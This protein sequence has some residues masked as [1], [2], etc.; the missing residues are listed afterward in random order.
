M[1]SDK[2]TSTDLIDYN[3]LVGAVNRI[4]ENDDLIPST[5][6]IF[7]DW[8]SG[9]SSLMRMV[10][11][12]YEG[13][14]EILT[15]K[16]N[17][18]LFEGYE[19]AKSVL[20][21]TILEEIATNRTLSAEAKEIA[22]RLFKKIDWLKLAKN[23][24]KYGVSLATLGPV[25]LGISALSDLPKMLSEV[26]Y[27][28]FI[29]SPDAKDKEESLRMSIREFHSDFKRLLSETKISKLIV[30]IDDLDRCMPDT[31]IDTLEAIKLFLYTD[32]TA[33]VISADEQL[34]E[35]AVSKR[36]PK[37]EGIRDSVSRDYLEKLIQYPIRIPQLSSSEIETY[38]N[39]LFTSLHIKEGFDTVRDKVLKKKN[40]SV[41]GSVYTFSNCEE[42]F[43]SSL[44][45]S[46]LREDLILSSQI[47][48]ILAEGL[49]GNPR[50]CKRFL[51]MFMM[52]VKMAEDKKLSIEKRILSKLMLL[53]YFRTETF[54]TI[55]KLQSSQEGKPVEI[56]F[57]EKNN[58]KT[59]D[60]KQNGKELH[61]KLDSSVNIDLWLKDD[62]LI[63]WFSM[64]PH[65]SNIDLRPYFYLSRDK[66]ASISS[67]SSRMNPKV[68]ELL[69]KL[70]SKSEIIKKQALDEVHTLNPMDANNILHVLIKNIYKTEE[71]EP[72]ENL[73]KS[74]N[75][76]CESRKELLSELFTFYDKFPERH[77]SQA[78]IPQ[79]MS[80]VKGTS[81]VENL[82]G[83]LEKWS[84]NPDNK[85]LAS[86]SQ[87][88]LKKK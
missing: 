80:A 18:W 69:N 85:L 40:E 12:S 57:I 37:M 2:D 60:E 64:K 35:Y 36:F 30:F 74:V 14:E 49:N 34:I 53:E 67:E 48:P 61:A 41:F 77:L 26:D 58:Q 27:E 22:I 24:L 8:G 25:G 55:F 7:G 23:G 5:I 19:D 9:K 68:E 54:K 17:G 62:W 31:I 71:D 21:G 66:I 46:D 65:L 73:I 13:K 3:H 63:K 33:F 43:D 15:V 81:Y 42:F 83:L 10:E 39:L 87:K 70:T 78:V 1:W 72:R 16:F 45:T 20:M 28:K 11:E 59:S 75:M 50:Q 82:N 4:I 56:K 44:N 47:T 79:L 51:N 29:K 38:I 84:K 32:N 52:R 76:F 6:G 86:I 88:T